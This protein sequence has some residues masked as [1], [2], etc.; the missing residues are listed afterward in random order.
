MEFKK[1]SGLTKFHTM[2]LWRNKAD[3]K[4]FAQNEAH[5]YAIKKSKSIAKKVKTL[6]IEE[7]TLPDWKEAILLLESK[8][9][10]HVLS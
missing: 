9:K 8:G 2:T 5:K 3:L 10:T 7:Y 6:T 4:R 1:K